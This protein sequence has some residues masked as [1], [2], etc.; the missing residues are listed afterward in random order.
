M[1]G[2]RSASGFHEKMSQDRREAFP[3]KEVPQ[4]VRSG[5]VKK[6]GK[7]KGRED[8]V[9]KVNR[10]NSSRRQKSIRTCL[11]QISQMTR[12]DCPT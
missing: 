4:V 6:K 1:Q 10:M 8:C 5:V 9:G 3:P 7:G 2:S 12:H 11:N